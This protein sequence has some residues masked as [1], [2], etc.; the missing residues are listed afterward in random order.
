LVFSVQFN[1]HVDQYLFNAAMARAPAPITIFVGHMPVL[2]EA[3]GTPSTRRLLH[4]EAT[5]A[6][7]APPS[8][9][10]AFKSCM[11]GLPLYEAHANAETEARRLSKSLSTQSCSNIPSTM[12]TSQPL[13]YFWA[14][15][16]Q[17]VDE[18]MPMLT[19]TVS[20]RF[21]SILHDATR[22]KDIDNLAAFS[23][24]GPPGS[25]DS[26]AAGFT[27]PV[28]PRL[29]PDLVNVGDPI[30]SARSDGV[31]GS[32]ECRKGAQHA[33]TAMSGTS[34]ACPLTAGSATLVRQYLMENIH[35]QLDGY[36]TTCEYHP[37]PT[38]PLTSPSA[39]LLKAALI[40]GTVPLT[41]FIGTESDGHRL[42]AG[43]PNYE[44]GFGRVNLKHSVTQAGDDTKTIYLDAGSHSI[45]DTGSA[46]HSDA[47]GSTSP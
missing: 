25:W 24:R 44:Q 38:S 39:A 15:V 17:V 8:E 46:A 18:C 34:M 41:G 37:A 42:A 22:V 2:P 9:R 11:L 5:L 6:R 12:A 21:T 36:I 27:G 14:T 33:L 20:V 30:V 26:D 4:P 43:V 29:K 32:Y 13:D 45:Y 23:G 10:A 1:Y 47:A 16:A 19:G 31:P 3:L 7:F 35:C 40:L 28:H